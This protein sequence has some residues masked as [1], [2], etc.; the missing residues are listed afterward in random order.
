MICTMFMPSLGVMR[1]DGISARGRHNDNSLGYVWHRARG[2][3]N[4]IS[5]G[6]GRWIEAGEGAIIV[7]LGLVAILHV[8]AGWAVIVQ[9]ILDISLWRTK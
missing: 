6:A 2:R 3:Y 4:H 8:L 1:W 7:L 5:L 9:Y